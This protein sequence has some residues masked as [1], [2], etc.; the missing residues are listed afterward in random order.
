MVA[1][2]YGVMI[3]D[4]FCFPLIAQ[5]IADLLFRNAMQKL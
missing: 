4:L 3:F 2:E 5:I 1:P